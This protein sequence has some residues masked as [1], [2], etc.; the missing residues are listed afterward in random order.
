MIWISHRQILPKD[1][2]ARFPVVVVMLQEFGESCRMR[3]GEHL[4]DLSS[5]LNSG[6]R[7]DLSFSDFCQMATASGKLSRQ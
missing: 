1:F 5:N 3:L 6:Y 4:N 2:I 7:A